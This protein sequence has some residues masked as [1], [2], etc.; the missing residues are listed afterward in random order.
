MDIIIYIHMLFRAD[1]VFVSA[2]FMFNPHI[3]SIKSNTLDVLLPKYELANP[4]K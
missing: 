1:G 3:L 2:I 4:L